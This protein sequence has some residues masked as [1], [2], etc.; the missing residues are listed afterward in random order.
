[1]DI[2]SFKK[3][4][5]P[6]LRAQMDAFVR[7]ASGQVSDI[8]LRNLIHHPET[9]TLS[10]GK[11][12]R[13]YIAFL[14]YKVFNGK[15]DAAALRL[16]AA[17]EL[18][19]T[20]ALIHDDIIDRGNKRH[21]KETTHR[22]AARRLHALKRRGEL[23][24]I[25]ESQAILVGDLLLSWS[26]ESLEQGLAKEEKAISGTVRRVYHAMIEEVILGQMIDVD[27]TTRRRANTELI[28]QK[29]RMKT[30]GY[31]FVR[32]L[33]IGAAFAG[34]GKTVE[35]FTKAF[36]EPLGVAFQIQDDLFDVMSSATA[37]QKNVMT[38]LAE[39]QHTVFTQYV[40]EHG[41]AAEK[42]LL[43]S[44]MGSSLTKKDCER[45][46]RLFEETGAIAYGKT[47]IAAELDICE[48]V[49]SRAPFS[50]KQAQPLSE[51]VELIRARKA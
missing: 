3:R 9:I 40:F 10:G 4:F 34:G 27:L 51:L 36:G 37:I 22:F 1:M 35:S 50:K 14:G 18:F 45:A 16:F 19:H 44:L 30:A 25:A 33:M 28:Y 24:R 8:F 42:K 48:R 41:T 47:R 43:Q 17:L 49:L 39:H 13:P 15:K 5:D 7:R 11:R 2:V 20:F 32:P 21:G 46:R 12:L 38:D 26:F 6:F 23:N 29:M 31:S